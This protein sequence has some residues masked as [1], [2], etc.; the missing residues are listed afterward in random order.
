MTE[1]HQKMLE[2]IKEFRQ[3][4]GLPHNT[5]EITVP[6]TAIDAHLDHFEE[7]LK[8]YTDAADPI[9][10]IDAA[11]D[12]LIFALGGMSHAGVLFD[13]GWNFESSFTG[14]DR[15]AALLALAHHI[16]KC[17]KRIDQFE[18]TAFCVADWAIELVLKEFD[19]T[20]ANV[21]YDCF[22]IVHKS[23]MSKLC[24]SKA[25][26]ERTATE[27]NDKIHEAYLADPTNTPLYSCVPEETANGWA[28]RRNDGKLL[29]GPHFYA[30][31]PE[32]GNYYYR[33]KYPHLSL[34]AAKLADD[35]QR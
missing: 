13:Y 14:A 1:R 31:E 27:Y 3:F 19:S 8:E 26:A 28:I 20:D 33:I 15:E 22:E 11:V 9:S 7:E 29:K 23:N 2:S 35:E 5:E 10:R 21:F 12:L 32:L 4:H 18:L 17:R 34:E 16:D 30:P 24:K 25:Q 6:T